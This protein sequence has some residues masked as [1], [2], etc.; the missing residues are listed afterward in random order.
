M[1][2]GNDL[3]LSFS[4]EPESKLS[5]NTRILMSGSS[6]VGLVGLHPPRAHFNNK[7]QVHH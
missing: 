7:I 1:S 4:F 5:M 6:S 2:F 3:P